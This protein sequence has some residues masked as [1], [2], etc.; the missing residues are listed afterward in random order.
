MLLFLKNLQ[1]LE[2]E[3]VVWQNASSLDSSQTSFMRSA[4]ILC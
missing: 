4:G 3:N 2:M 1:K